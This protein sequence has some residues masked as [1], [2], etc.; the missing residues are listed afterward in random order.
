LFAVLLVYPIYRAVSADKIPIPGSE[1]DGISVAG[2]P[3]T[4][5]PI[6]VESALLFLPLMHYAPADTNSYFYVLDWDAALDSKSPPSATIE[7]KGMRIFR[8]QG[9]FAKHIVEGPAFLCEH[10]VFAMLDGERYQWAERRVL[11]DS[12][13]ASRV[14]GGFTT[15]HD[16]FTIRVVERR[17]GHTPAGCLP[18][19]A[20][21]GQSLDGFANSS[22]S[23]VWG[24]LE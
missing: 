17:H 9:F 13:F 11:G 16:T 22:V 19:A 4:T 1:L 20:K 6:A 14:V 3:I 12:A 21:T 24:L 7:T 8:R 10:P 23:P 18:K 15:M 5:L 2:K